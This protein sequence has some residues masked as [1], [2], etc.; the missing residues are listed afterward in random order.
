VAGPTAAV[1]Q[2]LA[3]PL[4]NKDDGAVGAFLH[5]HETETSRVLAQANG[6]PPLTEHVV[7]QLAG[8]YGWTHAID[9]TAAE[10]TDLAQRLVADW[11]TGNM[12]AISVAL[13]G[14]AVGSEAQTRLVHAPETFASMRTELSNW[15]LDRQA[16][17]RACGYCEW[18]TAVAFAQPDS[19]ESSHDSYVA[20]SNVSLAGHIARMQS[21]G[22]IDPTR[23]W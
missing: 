3:P 1:S 8:M 21:L 19:P 12:Y 23:R 22:A 14:C 11:R 2:P 4:A 18:I 13:Q 20:L 10:V 17:L 7:M 16:D 15:L 9:I 6:V 5:P